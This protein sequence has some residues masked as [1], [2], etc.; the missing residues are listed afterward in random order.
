MKKRIHIAT[1]SENAQNVIRRYWLNIELNDLC[2]SESLDE[3]NRPET[4]DRM[5]EEIRASKAKSVI[6]HGPFT[7]IIPASIDHRAVELGLTRLEEAYEVCRDMGIHRMAVHSGYMPLLYFKEWHHEKSVFFWKKFMEHK[8]ADF[9]IYIENVF[10]DEPVM[11]KKLI[12]DIGHPQVHLCL[13][14]GHANAVTSE[15][16]TVYDWIE[17]LGEH[18][19]HFHL[20][21][22]NGREDLHGSLTEGT[23]DMEKV[24]DCIDRCC[25]E[26]VTLTIES[27]SCEDS[28]VWICKYAEKQKKI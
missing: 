26:D 17:I 20:H 18:I 12:E 1:F 2:I 4:I 14:I 23:M 7:E 8:P 11:M 16:Y 24:L 9:H 28:A 10:E 15:A 13:D 22:N 19:G 6:M 5:R 25:C 3:E 21:N 27:R